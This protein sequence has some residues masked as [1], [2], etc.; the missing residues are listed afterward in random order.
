MMSLIQQNTTKEIDE[1]VNK[2]KL[3]IPLTETEQYLDS[4]VDSKTSKSQT[5]LLQK[6]LPKPESKTPSFATASST[7]KRLSVSFRLKKP[8]QSLLER[9]NLKNAN[10]LD[11]SSTNSQTPSVPDPKIDSFSSKAMH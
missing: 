10:S 9:R 6:T 2:D 11:N 8:R 1:V 7:N 4:A 5:D 3:L